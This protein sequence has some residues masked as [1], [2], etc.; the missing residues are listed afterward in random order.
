M[1]IGIAVACLAVLGAVVAYNNFFRDAQTDEPPTTETNVSTNPGEEVIRSYLEQC[2][3]DSP[4]GLVLFYDGDGSGQTRRL[5]VTTG[6][7]ESVTDLPTPLRKKLASA[8]GSQPHISDPQLLAAFVRDEVAHGL[9]LF[10]ASSMLPR[11]THGMIDF[12]KTLMAGYKV[13]SLI[14]RACREVTLSDP[15]HGTADWN[16][17]TI[18]TEFLGAVGTYIHTPPL[19]RRDRPAAYMMS[20]RT[21]DELAEAAAIFPQGGLGTSRSR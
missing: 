7:Y 2:Q 21:D 9:L 5:L 3:L 4:K 18:V 16:A 15:A 19:N 17:Q 20:I 10:S 6:R 12:L 14:E 8:K 1:W 13:Q 11:S